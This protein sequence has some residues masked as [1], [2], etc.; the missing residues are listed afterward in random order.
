ML[1][2]NLSERKFVLRFEK[3]KDSAGNEILNPIL[4]VEHEEESY[5]FDETLNK[6]S[7]FRRNVLSKKFR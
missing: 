5:G 3:I 6:H 4:A 1:Y 2:K 7:R